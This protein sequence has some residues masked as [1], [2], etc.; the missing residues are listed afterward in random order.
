MSMRRL[1]KTT[2]MILAVF[3]ALLVFVVS[4]AAAA[5]P[6]KPPIAAFNHWPGSN[7]LT[8]VFEDDSFDPDSAIVTWYWDFGD[9]QFSDEQNPVHT[10]SDSGT[11]AVT[12]TITADDGTSDSVTKWVNVDNGPTFFLWTELGKE[13]GNW[14]VDLTWS[15]GPTGAVDV[16]RDLDPSPIATVETESNNG[17]YTDWIGRKAEHLYQVCEHGSLTVCSNVS[18]AN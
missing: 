5:K 12:L 2:V 11:Y 13:K 14:K 7:P 18:R 16:Y 1:L 8:E 9:G 15:G 6:N 10:Y 17:S 3:I 4:I